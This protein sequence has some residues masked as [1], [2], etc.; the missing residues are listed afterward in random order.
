MG[1]V[2]KAKL[3]S[4]LF[5]FFFEICDGFSSPTATYFPIN[6]SMRDENNQKYPSIRDVFQQINPSMRDF[7]YICCSFIHIIATSYDRQQTICLHG[8]AS[9]T[10]PYVA[11]QIQI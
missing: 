10:S 6:P 9:E 1:L 5:S 2:E 3:F 4:G 11:R 7:E 8:G